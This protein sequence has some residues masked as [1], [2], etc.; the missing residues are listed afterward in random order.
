MFHPALLPAFNEIN[1]SLIC[2]TPLLSLGLGN[3][4]SI[5]W[6]QKILK[7]RGKHNIRV[8][9]GAKCVHWLSST[10]NVDFWANMLLQ[11][12]QMLALLHCS[13]YS[14]IICWHHQWHIPYWR[15][16]ICPNSLS[17]NP[18][19]LSAWESMLLHQCICPR[20]PA[21]HWSLCLPSS[22]RQSFWAESRKICIFNAKW[23]APLPNSLTANQFLDTIVFSLF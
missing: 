7:G 17:G 19:N 23:E 13:T 1:A 3:E 18:L 6:Q 12:P 21:A 5:V 22:L 14:Y 15:L 4:C 20:K 11:T 16:M 2:I 9:K 8:W 10:L